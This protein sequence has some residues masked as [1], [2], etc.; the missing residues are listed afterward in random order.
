MTVKVRCKDCAAFHVGKDA[1][2]FAVFECRLHPKSIETYP[3][4]W[5][6]DAPGQEITPTPDGDH[7]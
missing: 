2:S 5:C 1:M 3:D 6:L 7:E 4:R